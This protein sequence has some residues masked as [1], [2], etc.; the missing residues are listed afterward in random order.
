[1]HLEIVIRDG[2][3]WVLGPRDRRIAVFAAVL[4]AERVGDAWVF[5]AKYERAVR[6][7]ARKLAGVEKTPVDG[8]AAAPEANP[9]S[10]TVSLARSLAALLDPGLTLWQHLRH[11]HEAAALLDASRADA[12]TL[13]EAAAAFESLAGRLRDAAAARGSSSA[14][15]T[16]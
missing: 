9:P 14:G 5:D 3:L 2:K 12:A 8:I 10:S 13:E 7:F 4:R 16:A 15:A 11:A 6:D 1:M